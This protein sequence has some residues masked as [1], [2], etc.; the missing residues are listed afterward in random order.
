MLTLQ[1]FIMETMRAQKEQLQEEVEAEFA[2]N[3]GPQGPKGKDLRNFRR[4]KQYRCR[5]REKAAQME[6][7]ARYHAPDA[8]NDPVILAEYEQYRILEEKREK[9]E[10]ELIQEIRTV[11]TPDFLAQ[12]VKQYEPEIQKIAGELI[13][14]YFSSETVYLGTYPS[15]E[16][17][18]Y[19]LPEE[20]L[21][22]E[23]MELFLDEIEENPFYYV[24]SSIFLDEAQPDPD[25]A[26]DGPL[27]LHYA[28]ASFLME[29][30]PMIAG[31]LKTPAVIGVVYH[32]VD[33][34][35]K[36][37][38]NEDELIENVLEEI[39]SG[40]HIL[41][42]LEKNSRYSNMVKTFRE[43]RERKLFLAENVPQS[44]PEDFASLYPHAR[45]L[46]RKFVLHLGPT[47]SGKTYEAMQALSEANTGIYL[48]PLRLLAFE[49]YEKL[50]SQGIPCSLVTGEERM[51]TEGARIQSS[52]VEI[53]DPAVHYDVAVIDEAQMLDDPGRGGAWTAAILGAAADE[54]HVCASECAEKILIKL[55]EH[56]GDEYR[57]VRHKRAVPLT[58][59]QTEFRFPQSVRKGDALIVFSRRSVHA[60]AA[61][62]QSRK[63]RC[64]II[65]GSLP[66]DVRQNEATRFLNGETD[67]VVATD[68]IGLGMNLPI[69]RVVF[70]EMHKFDGTESR[71]LS[72][73]EILQIA[74]RA[75]RMGMYEEGYVTCVYGKEKRM[76][77]QAFTA[78]IPQ[79]K[80]AV[81]TPPYS[82]TRL[83]G[84]LSE[85]YEAWDQMELNGILI[86][87]DVS[88][89]IRL[90]KALEK[91]TDDKDLIYAFANIPFDAEN[92]DLYALWE[93]LFKGELYG[94]P[95][96]AQQFIDQNQLNENAKDL[97]VLEYRYKALD[98]LYYY[99]TWADREPE[100]EIVM[101]KKQ[102]LS[103][104]IIRIL[105][106]SRLEK[107]K[108]PECGHFLPWNYPYRI[109]QDCFTEKRLYGRRYNGYF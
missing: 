1:Q 101:E 40:E 69:R 56:C 10:R 55:I 32:L 79:I 108:C 88:Q 21:S 43:T 70:L 7:Y 53:L 37:T 42:L 61:E 67:V 22:A 73:P 23:N 52:T 36:R 74:G 105:S 94:T 87:G 60:V 104:R 27:P 29:R 71:N 30:D 19:L 5:Y 48:G 103:K 35:V 100:T 66:Y 14:R 44:I 46:H 15:Y 11:L 95:V 6:A 84:K 33:K 38:V 62:L 18:D 25:V 2:S 107:R 64:S 89:V 72:A 20:E 8:K 47:N 86:K 82:I 9:E 93:R 54:I 57:I 31:Y 63:I 77:R 45:R 102:D 68:A 16:E 12:R 49:Q 81:I 28:A 97:S 3:F 4:S 24:E 51:I 83:E 98:L 26:Y 13:D 17:T 59:E 39:L 78:R 65:Y 92:R 91:E 41:D 50:S 34:A 80:Q 96:T 75:G 58:V 106:K 85:I 109:C 99:L 76:I 90:C